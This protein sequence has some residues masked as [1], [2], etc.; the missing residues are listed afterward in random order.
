MS[1]PKQYEADVAI[2][3]A[4][5]AGALLSYELTKKGLNVICLEAG[6]PI[7]RFQVM[8]N[9]KAQVSRDFQNPYPNPPHAPRPSGK[10]HDE[11]VESVGKND[12][13]PAYL[14][15]V[16]GTTW[17][18]AGHAWR[19]LEEDFKEHSLYGVGRDMPLHYNDLE[20]Y[21]Q[22]AEMLMGVSGVSNPL[23]YYQFKRSKPY[24]LAPLP[25][26]Y[27]D[28]FVDQNI[29]KV[30]LRVKPAPSARN[31]Q[32][33][34]E[35]P[36]CCG[37]NNCMPICPLGAQYS[38]IVHIQKAQQSKKFTLLSNV[39][40]DHI[41]SPDHKKVESLRARTPNGDEI[42][43]R[44]HHYVLTGGG[45]EIPKL[46]L[47]S[48]VGNDNVGRYL[49][50][51]PLMFVS[52]MAKK[53]VFPGRGPMVVGSITD[54]QTG[55]FRRSR[56]GLR[57]NLKNFFDV[58]GVSANYIQQGY[59]GKTLREKIDLHSR[60]I[61]GLEIFFGQHPDRNN[62]ITLSPTRKDALGIPHPRVEYEV[63]PWTE[64]SL[65]P[66]Y[67]ACSQIAIACDFE[68]GSLN[69][70]NETLD[71]KKRYHANNHFMG[72]TI[73][74]SD[75]KDSA[76]DIWGR[77][78]SRKTNEPMQNLFVA[79]S[80]LLAGTGVSNVSLTIAALALRLADHLSSTSKDFNS[81]KY[82]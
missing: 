39:V 12:Y 22:K 70:E 43:I 49:M 56:A 54:F 58:Q 52:F 59:T 46:L 8:Q 64:R 20:P 1:E 41:T 28:Q 50:D 2:V 73:M 76:T 53:D 21:Y 16:G 47:L 11:Y 13:N 18:W 9:F 30:G 31:T 72:T 5:L 44:A 35:R 3:G 36:P 66:A 19:F 6:P 55:D 33:Y 40:V 14:R 4:G 51:H 79:S 10:Y 81:N 7:E 24:P 57:I 23:D 17:H 48:E 61:I 69:F 25:L 15:G 38:A 80:S 62:R 75:P 67:D 42:R 74:G 32:V 29:A 71:P 68:N 45:I 27:L 82:Y 34:D 60:R 37:S 63:G 65:K 77:I 78:Y 26:S